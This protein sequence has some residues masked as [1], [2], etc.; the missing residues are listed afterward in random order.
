MRPWP[1]SAGV[2]ALAA[3]VLAAAARAQ[4]PFTLPPV[5]PDPAA[6]EEPVFDIRRIE[7]TGS[8]IVDPQDLQQIAAPYAGRRVGAAELENLRQRLTRHL[9]ERGFVN[10]G[11]VLSEPAP[12][13]GVLRLQVVA[14]RVAS[15]RIA[16]LDGLREGYVRGRL[17][18]EAEETLNLEVLR[19]RFQL[20]LEDPLIARGDAR[21]VPGERRGEAILDL[22]LQ[23]AR[24]Y[25]LT[26]FANN[27][28]PPSIGAT[29][30]GLAGVVR[31]LT[32]WGDALE[33]SWAQSGSGS[34]SGR[35]GMSW[36]VP[37]N[38]RGTQLF[39]QLDHGRSSVIE[40]P[41]Q[42]FDI[43]SRIDSRE[44]GIT[45]TLFERY[46]R[47][48]GLGLSHL[49]RANST[50]LAGE[51]FSFTPAE[52]DG[53]TRTR[54]WR[55]WQEYSQRSTVQ[56]WVARSTFAFTRTNLQPIEGLPDAAMLPARRYGLWL[57]QAQ[58]GRRISEGGTQFVARASAQV[59]RDRLPALDQ[60]AVGGV[61][62]V[63]GYRENQLLRD[64]GL[65]FNL[66][67]DIP[68]RPEGRGPWR[69]SVVPFYDHGRASN[70]G[71]PAD[72]LSSAGVATRLRYKGFSVD[73]AVARRIAHPAHV[74][75]GGGNLQDKGVH[76]RIAYDLFGD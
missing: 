60:M 57:G 62:S 5:P 11:I 38:A 14:G 64:T 34:D 24:P 70:R 67:L 17:W 36:R 12:A 44:L 4:S 39:V 10:S 48:F 74:T 1:R 23:R 18:P 9:V 59:A 45:Q 42:Q 15:V 47:K 40:E 53:T 25:Q 58:Y 76:F 71:E 33:A 8:H 69:L 41:L 26:L 7:I 68:L 21:I 72:R 55:F 52:P 31:N 13:E 27:Y 22:Q 2:A 73:L 30:Y 54:S 50:T 16:G 49:R 19:E 37:V 28:R 3:L 20:L 63:R 6:A 61:Y 56:A 29:N 32:G 35:G 43:R 46:D 66:E 75:D 51:P 65:V